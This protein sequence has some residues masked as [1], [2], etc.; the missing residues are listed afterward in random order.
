M[1]INIVI[2]HEI[3]TRTFWITIGLETTFVVLAVKLW[4]ENSVGYGGIPVWAAIQQFDCKLMVRG[5]A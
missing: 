2:L 5:V 1:L 3:P 4:A